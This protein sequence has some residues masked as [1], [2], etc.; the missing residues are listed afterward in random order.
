MAVLQRCEHPN[1]MWLHEIIN[2]PRKNE[3][4]LVTEYY[5]GG[6]LHDLVMKRNK[7]FEEHNEICKKEDRAE[8]M[9]TS[10]LNEWKARIYFID[11]LKALDYCH[12]IIGVI[13][14]DIKPDNI[15]INHN[16]EAVLIDFG[17]SALLDEQ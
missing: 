15:M 4:Y 2:D 16:K 3:L 17:V 11:M 6:S 9:M 10:G 1:I 13:H 12:N 14:R 7:K 8:E 5:K